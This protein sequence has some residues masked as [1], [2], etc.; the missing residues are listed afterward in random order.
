M[1]KIQDNVV[2]RATAALAQSVASI[3]GCDDDDEVKHAALAESFSQFQ[4]FLEKADRDTFEKIFEKADDDGGDRENGDHDR[5][6]GGGL[7]NHPVVQ[8]AR[9]LVASGKFGDH[10]QA[11]DHLLNTARGVALVR[12]H[13][14]AT[15]KESN[16]DSIHAIMKSGGI[17]ATCAAIV[18]KGSTSI[19]EHALVDAATSV[20][21]DRHPELSPAQAFSKV[22]T[23][24]TDEARV[25]REAL[26]IAQQPAVILGGDLRDADDAAQAMDQLREIGRRMAPTATPAKQFAVA[27]EDPKNVAL[28]RRAY[29][30]PTAPPSGAYPMPR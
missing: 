16:M 4:T 7:A 18:A 14:A 17:G 19:S 22:F 10:A 25:L 15:E 3:L 24:S 23:D 1:A 6:G 20:A 28:A 11:L 26:K 9:L 12:T 5:D 29:S 21:S 30:R 13:K 27:F 8:L 2:A